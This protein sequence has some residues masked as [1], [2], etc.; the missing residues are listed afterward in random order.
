M[1]ISI[2]GT[3]E[4]SLGLNSWH[5]ISNACSSGRARRI[6][7]FKRLPGFTSRH[8]SSILCVQQARTNHRQIRG[9]QG[10]ETEYLE[11]FKGLLHLETLVDCFGEYSPQYLEVFSAGKTVGSIRNICTKHPAHL[12][13]SSK[14]IMAG[15]FK[16][17]RAIAMRCFCPPDICTPPSPTCVSYPSG[18]P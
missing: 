16:T 1:P 6:H 9:Q 4:G 18:N 14:S 7:G 11:A 17:A 15:S 8:E 13:A 5:V 12:V 2:P 3:N 10:T